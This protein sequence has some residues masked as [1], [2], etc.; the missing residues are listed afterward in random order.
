MGIWAEAGADHPDPGL[1]PPPP[2]EVRD[3]LVTL[4]VSRLRAVHDDQVSGRE[5]D[6]AADSGDDSAADSTAAAALFVLLAGGGKL[7]LFMTES[8]A[9]RASSLPS[10]LSNRL[11]PWPC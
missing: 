5:D 6:P 1:A 11:P 9:V 8:C 10:S 7:R 2:G 3:R 4:A